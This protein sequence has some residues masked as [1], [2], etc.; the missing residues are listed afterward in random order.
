MNGTQRDFTFNEGVGAWTS[1]PRLKNASTETS[2]DGSFQRISFVALWAFTL[3]LYARPNDLFPDQLG[4]APVEK[5]IAIVG[6][7][8]FVVGTLTD[9]R[10]QRWP[11]ELRMVLLI[12][13][14]AVVLMPFAESR[15]TSLE[16]LVNT[17]LKVVCIFYL[18][19]NLLDNRHRIRMI[20]A[21]IVACGTVLAVH[22]IRSYTIGD[23]R[24]QGANGSRIIGA[25]GGMFF[26]PNDLATTFNILLPMAV[27]LGMLSR[28]LKRVVWLGASVILAGAVI[29]TFSRGGFL[30]LVTSTAFQG[31][32]FVKR[33]PILGTVVLTTLAVLLG[34]GFDLFP[35]T[36][37]TRLSSMFVPL[38]EADSSRQERT[39]LLQHAVEVA[40]TPRHALVGVGLA[41]YK[42]FSLRDKGAHNA[43][44]EISA[45]L[46]VAGLMA[47]LVMLVAPLAALR[48]VERETASDRL[49]V[50][51]GSQRD[52][53][54]R[55]I[56]YLSV[57]LQASI[58]AYMVCSFFLS[59]EYNWYVYYPLALA[60]GVKY[61]HAQERDSQM[62]ATTSGSLRKWSSRR[63]SYIHGSTG[64]LC[65]CR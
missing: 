8:A 55:E 30:A 42:I 60:A 14:I 17:W 22:A 57:G 32:R 1:K 2:Q 20:M 7:V 26:D 18:L 52:G 37:V 16:F 4:L 13:A 24:L 27:A 58:L 56:H 61:L 5:F 33:A 43:Y 62:T 50:E 11:L 36:Y 19:V 41:N 47:Y 23:L 48:R 59:I 21:L 53:R 63:T 51:P 44:L 49:R 3:V 34:A 6:V 15:S 25:V 9:G 10:R 40:F 38:A 12:T 35:Q 54:L 46:S 64:A 28:G 29:V 39:A 65:K 45:E 31:W